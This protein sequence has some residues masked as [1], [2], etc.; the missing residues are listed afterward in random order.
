T[1][2]ASDVPEQLPERPARARR[3]RRGLVGV[4]QQ[5]GEN[6]VLLDEYVRVFHVAQA[7][8]QLCAQRGVHIVDASLRQGWRGFRLGSRAAQRPLYGPSA[9]MREM[10]A[11]TA[12]SVLIAPAAPPTPQPS[13]TGAH[14]VL[15]ASSGR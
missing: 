8:P 1:V 4:A 14:V 12:L 13:L 6:T 7:T 15:F 2:T 9:P 5:L 11:I 3:H 10:F